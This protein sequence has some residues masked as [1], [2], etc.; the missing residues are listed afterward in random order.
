MR[1]PRARLLLQCSLQEL[2]QRDDVIFSTFRVFDLQRASYKPDGRLM[3]SV[4][5][6]ADAVLATVDGSSACACVVASWSIEVGV[7]HV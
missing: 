4:H 3:A 2:D 7:L 5:T 1:L 6:L